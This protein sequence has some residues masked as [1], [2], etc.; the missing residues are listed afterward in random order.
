V[1]IA[2]V[3]LGRQW[4]WKTW[5]SRVAQ[6]GLDHVSCVRN[7]WAEHAWWRQ[8]T[9]AAGLACA[10]ACALACLVPYATSNVVAEVKCKKHF[11]N[12]KA[13]CPY[14][15]CPNWRDLGG[16]DQTVDDF[17]GR[18]MPELQDFFGSHNCKECGKG[19]Y[20]SGGSCHDCPFFTRRRQYRD[21][22]NLG[23]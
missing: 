16:F 3:A 6:C 10:L 14:Q 20:G 7:Q 5:E 11:E 12:K 8:P 18:Y 1:F 21:E 2:V 22:S 4:T 13:E 23:C 15:N 19:K 17:F 9:R